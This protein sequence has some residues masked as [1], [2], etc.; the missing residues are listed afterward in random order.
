MKHKRKEIWS[1][2]RRELEYVFLFK[3]AAAGSGAASAV[4]LLLCPCNMKT[5]GVR[6]NSPTIMCCSY[7]V[8]WRVRCV[9]LNGIS[10]NEASKY[11]EW[12]CPS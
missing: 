2:K 12:S 9:G 3:M 4:D 7:N 6:Y 8:K 1:A 11:N 5:V 10:S